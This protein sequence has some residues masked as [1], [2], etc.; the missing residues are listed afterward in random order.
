MG[1]HTWT[2]GHYSPA[3]VRVLAAKDKL[4]GPADLVNLVDLKDPG[5]P[6][7]AGYVRHEEDWHVSNCRVTLSHVKSQC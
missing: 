5:M 4:L 7:A 3:G 1:T 6:Q 2:A